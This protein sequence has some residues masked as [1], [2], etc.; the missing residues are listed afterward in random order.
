MNKENLVVMDIELYKNYFL[1]LFQKLSNGKVIMFD[2]IDDE[3]IDIKNILHICKKYT[4]VT[5]NGLKY[6]QLILESLI[7]GMANRDLKKISDMIITERLQPWQVRKYTGI[8][9]MDIDHIDLIEVAPLKASLKIYGGRLHAPKLQDLPIPPDALIKPSE[10]PLMRRYCQN[11]TETT[12]ILFDALEKQLDLRETMSEEY[13]VDLRSKSDAQIAEAVIKSD[14]QKHYGI[15]PK[16]PSIPEGTV[17]KFQKPKYMKFK[18][19]YMQAILTLFC[20]ESFVLNAAGKMVMP[21]LIKKLTIK[22]GN[23]KYNPGIGGLHSKEK[24]T[25]HNKGNGIL[26]DYD[27]ASYYPRMILNNKLTPDHLGEPFL[28]IFEPIVERRL[29]AKQQKNKPVNESLKIVING[30]FGK[31]G[32]KYSII[33][34]PNLMIQTTI[35]GQLSL[36]ML[37]ESMELAGIPV[38]NANTDGIVVKMSKEQEKLAESIVSDWE[39]ETAYDMEST[40]Y[41]SL[42]SRDVNNYIAVKP[43]SIKCKGAYADESLRTNP[44]NQVCVDAVKAYLQQGSDIGNYIRRCTDITK[45]ITIRTVNGGAV[46]NAILLGKA[47]RWYYGKYELD[48]IF[49][50]TNGNKVPRSD[51]AIPIMDFDGSFPDDVDYEWYIDEAYKFLN[52]IGITND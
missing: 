43:D 52:Q 47:V 5:F 13:G 33:F 6:D 17:Y 21:D 10:V 15:T 35:I 1:I 30:L 36:L 11:D 4:I 37:I 51:G 29:E 19:D 32:S 31:F 9:P 41:I 24:K 22:I 2:R 27:A 26:R 25:S 12:G 18:T 45:F 40:D 42:N 20:E 7:A 28:K 16:R 23:T 14:F 44:V 8:R 49:Y 46:K 48:A 34:A 3:K 38:V 50:S 39:F